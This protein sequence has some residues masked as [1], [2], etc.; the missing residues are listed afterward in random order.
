MRSGFGAVSIAQL[1]AEDG[2][3]MASKTHKAASRHASQLEAPPRLTTDPAP[4]RST[5]IRQV[6]AWVDGTDNDWTVL[7][8]A[9][10]VAQRFGS[11]IDVLH[12][13]FDVRGESSGAQ[14]ER[15]FDRLLAVP[16]ERSAAEGAA[17]ARSHFEEWQTQCGLP[18]RDTASTASAASEPSTRWRQIIGYES[19]VVAR[20]GRLSDLIVLPRPNERASPTSLM[21]LETAL[22]DT[23]RPVL[24][25]PAG[26]T[27]DLFHRPLIAW[28][29]SLEAAR[30]VGFALPFLEQ[31]DD[32]VGIFVAPESKHRTETD[33]LH[34]YLGWHGVIAERFLLQ[35]A[36]PVGARLLAQ[37]QAI[38]AS[39]IV[40]GAYTHGHYR[41]F[42]FGGV[43]RHVIEHAALPILLAH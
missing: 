13:R 12:V 33:E 28:N 29:G 24:L 1:A 42:L 20:L 27:A 38:Q 35:D 8:H 7:D 32:L 36:R 19:E 18:C 9:L 4:S 40:M 39:M 5:G 16:V 14:A 30:A 11:H 34:Y 26:S 15:S 2:I 43:T 3:I 21:A 23:C 41:Q 10:Q 37:A 17:R 25:V 6:L 22:F 31:C